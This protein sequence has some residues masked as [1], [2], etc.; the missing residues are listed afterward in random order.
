MLWILF[1]IFACMHSVTLL[2]NSHFQMK[3]HWWKYVNL[4]LSKVSQAKTFQIYAAGVF[5][6]KI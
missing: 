6:H 5:Y 1:N 3:L 2:H 4:G